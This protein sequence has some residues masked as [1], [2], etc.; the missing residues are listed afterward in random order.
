MKI[1]MSQKYADRI[2]FI[3]EQAKSGLSEL[4]ARKASEKKFGA[5]HEHHR[6]KRIYTA[7]KAGNIEVEV[8]RGFE[9]TKKVKAKKT[10]KMSAKRIAAVQKAEKTRK[11]KR[12]ENH[13]GLKGQELM[14]K[15]VE[16]LATSPHSLTQHGFTV[17]SYIGADGVGTLQLQMP[18]VRA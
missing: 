2:P 5:K 14:K 4:D 3:T 12:V 8:D 1:A 10:G 16:V 9:K 13:S 17:T 11:A 18:Q 7:I 6:F 15:V